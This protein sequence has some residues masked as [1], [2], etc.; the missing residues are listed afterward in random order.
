MAHA[1]MVLI[2]ET[3]SGQSSIKI[4]K[5]QNMSMANAAAA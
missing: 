3:L 2:V 1:A 5:P 4:P